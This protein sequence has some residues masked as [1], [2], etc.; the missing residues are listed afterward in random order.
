MTDSEKLRTTFNEDADRYNQFRP[1][2]PPELFE[3]L[4]HDTQLPPDA[5][6][7][8]I[9]PGTG[10]A[11]E[12]LAKEGYKITAVE[13]GVELANKAR[14]VLAHYANVEVITGA[15]ED[16][17]LPNNSFDLIYSATAFH[18]VK[19]EVKFTK[20]SALLKPGGH[21]AI[22]HTEHVSD[23]AG[24]EFFFAS[25]PIF[26]KY[27]TSVQGKDDDFRLPHAAQLAP[28]SI[29]GNYFT[30][31]SFTKFPLTIT[32]SA[33]DYAGLLGTYSPIIALAPNQR[34]KFL[35]EIAELID[36][37]FGGQAD[38]CFAMTL[39]IAKRNKG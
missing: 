3:K 10:Q 12:P 26:S 13:L 4:I 16:V 30:F 1:H 18:W 6:L 29:D 8:E 33:Q 25:K 39:A 34:Q 38:R 31:E 27:V 23:E 17:Q 19:P 37:K 22:I 35:N 5:R 21:L 32:Y 14:Q 7:L 9:G 28:P 15:F 20:T 11:T 2:Y 24:D 36:S